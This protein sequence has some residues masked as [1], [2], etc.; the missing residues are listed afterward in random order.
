[1]PNEPDTLDPLLITVAEMARLLGIGRTEAY[2]IINRGLVDA[3]YQGRRRLVLLDSVR[4]YA[5]SLPTER[6]ED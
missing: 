5:A 2:V 3:R 4:E 6:I 1:M